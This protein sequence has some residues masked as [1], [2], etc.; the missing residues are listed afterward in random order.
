LRLQGPSGITGIF[1]IPT[2]FIG[3]LR[4]DVSAGARGH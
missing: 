3:D 1:H 4:L 2:D